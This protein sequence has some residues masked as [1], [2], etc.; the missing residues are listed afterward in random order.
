MGIK[1]RFS[2]FK[3]LTREM[4]M[5]TLVQDAATIRRLAGLC[6]RRAPLTQRLRLLGVRVGSL[7]EGAPPPLA[8]R[9]GPRP[10]LQPGLRQRRCGGYA[11][12]VW[13]LRGLVQQLS[14]QMA[15]AAANVKNADDLLQPTRLLAQRG[16]GGGR[17]FH[18]RGVLLGHLVKLRDGD[19]HL[20][21]AIALLVGGSW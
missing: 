9:M 20:G 8:K 5:D 16:C 17:L 10:R 12:L 19:V 4:T 3:S 14:A 1:L 11:R 15:G 2:D 6:L 13:W 7:Q 18:Q 21:N